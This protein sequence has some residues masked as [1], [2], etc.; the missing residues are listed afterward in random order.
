MEERPSGEH[1]FNGG[2]SFGRVRIYVSVNRESES[3]SKRGV[4]IQE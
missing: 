3:K 4:W 2:E 1:S